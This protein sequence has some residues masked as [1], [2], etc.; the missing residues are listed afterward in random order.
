MQDPQKKAAC[1]FD[2]HQT[3]GAVTVSVFSKVANPYKTTIKAN[4][5][6]LKLSITFDGD[7]SVF[8]KDF[9]LKGVSV[10]TGIH[11]FLMLFIGTEKYNFWE[12][13]CSL[14]KTC[15]NIFC[16]QEPVLPKYTLFKVFYFILARFKKYI[17][18]ILFS[19]KY[20]KNTL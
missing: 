10:N 3:P 17:L 20:F 4:R 14:V 13:L 6:S 19:V 11:N 5:V 1:R 8:E 16:N 2:W 9:I 12:L 7:K 15:E 18:F